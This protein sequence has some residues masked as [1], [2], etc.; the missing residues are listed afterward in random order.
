[1]TTFAT[2]PNSRSWPDCREFTP[3]ERSE[4]VMYTSTEPRPMR[5]EGMTSAAF[6]RVVYSV[7]S[8]EFVDIMRTE[9]RVR[10]S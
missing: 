10:C 5:A 4:I 9:P 2:T 1:M 3:D 6:D 8:D 7:S